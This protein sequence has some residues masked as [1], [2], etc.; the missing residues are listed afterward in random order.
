MYSSRVNRQTR[1]VTVSTSRTT[2]LHLAPSCSSPPHNPSQTTLINYAIPKILHSQSPPPCWPDQTERLNSSHPLPD[3]PPNLPRPTAFSSG[4][5]M[6]AA[7]LRCT[8][9]NTWNPQ[10]APVNAQAQLVADDGDLWTIRITRSRYVHQPFERI[11]G[12]RTP[13][14]AVRL[15]L[16]SPSKPHI[17]TSST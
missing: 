2:A 8:P 16:L 9:Y 15:I 6:P 17:I 12:I 13:S 3:P 11:S 10:S 1:T 14:G 7:G 4:C 5:I